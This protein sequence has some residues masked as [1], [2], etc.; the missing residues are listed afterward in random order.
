MLS[1]Y[2]N[3]YLNLIGRLLLKFNWSI[4]TCGLTFE[5]SKLANHMNFFLCNG[6][7]DI[8]K[9]CAEILMTCAKYC[10]LIIV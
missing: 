8:I 4:I 2:S 5:S 1:Y 10:T 9:S 6:I 7:P 3:Y